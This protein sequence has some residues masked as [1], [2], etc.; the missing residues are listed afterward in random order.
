MRSVP[1]PQ[2]RVRPIA[3]G[4]FRLGDSVLVAEGHDPVKNETFYR[5]L[6]G[7]IEFGEYGRD[8]VARE[9]RE[10]IGAEVTAGA[11]LAAIENIFVYDGKPGHEIVLIYEAEFNDKRFYE[12]MPIQGHDDGNLLFTALWKP[13][14]F[15]RAGGAPLYPTGLLEL[16]EQAAS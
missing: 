8:T 2:P 11:F 15:F 16:L 13:L 1:L 10:E 4:I 3:I 9:L 14:S 6:G 5:P 12:D 7:S